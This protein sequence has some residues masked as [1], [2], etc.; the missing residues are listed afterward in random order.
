MTTATKSRMTCSGSLGRALDFGERCVFSLRL[1]VG[2]ENVDVRAQIRV[3][4]S[5]KKGL[6]LCCESF[7]ISCAMVFQCWVSSRH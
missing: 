6:Q 7:Y 3:D 4:G 2:F 5:E 1:Y